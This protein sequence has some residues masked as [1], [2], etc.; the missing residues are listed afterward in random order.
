MKINKPLNDTEMLK[1]IH[2][3][4]ERVTE[5]HGFKYHSAEEMLGVI[6]EEIH[7]LLHA[8]H[9]GKGQVTTAVLGELIDVAVVC[10]RGA[11]SYMHRDAVVR[12]PL[13]TDDGV[14]G[15]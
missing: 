3:Q 9:E 14:H 15:L 1:V 4:L 7:E 8:V 2:D 6:S 11:R 13:T 10:V 12:D 5:R